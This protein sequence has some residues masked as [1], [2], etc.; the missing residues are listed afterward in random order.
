MCTVYYQGCRHG[1][2]WEELCE[3][4]Q[5]RPG[6]ASWF[7]W[8]RTR[9]AC[10]K[11]RSKVPGGSPCRACRQEEE[12]RRGE[13]DRRKTA[14]ARRQAKLAAERYGWHQGA[15]RQ[16]DSAQLYYYQAAQAAPRSHYLLFFK[17]SGN[18][19]G[20]D[21]NSSTYRSTSVARVPPQPPPVRGITANPNRGLP[22]RA[23]L[24]PPLPR[25]VIAER[26]RQRAS[27]AGIVSPLSAACASAEPQAREES[28][29]VKDE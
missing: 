2:H 10:K 23:A 28:T 26:A 6:R 21:N 18:S 27:Q 12:R 5:P 13:E 24:G 29:H 19:N 1:I 22:N 20:T 25:L 7:C 3:A 16:R 4:S 9:Q 8:A 17:T 15:A 11:S 14:E